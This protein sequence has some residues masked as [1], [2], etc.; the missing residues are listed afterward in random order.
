MHI[1][2]LNHY[3]GSPYYG[4]EYRPYYLA[5]EWLK[6]GHSVTI[7]AA[8]NSHIRRVNPSFQ[9]RYWEENI[10]GIHY[11]WLRTR[12]YNENGIRRMLNMLD[13]IHG[14]YSHMKHLAGLKPDVVIASSTY[15]LD[16]Y[17]AY[18]LA[19]KSRAQ[20]IYEV[21]DLWP[22]SP[23]KLGGYSKWH[24]FIVIMQIAENFA[25]RHVDK[26]VSILPCAESHMR[27][28]G[29]AEGKFFHVPNGIY[30]PEVEHAEPLDR[31]FLA[32]LPQNKKIIGYCGTLGKANA[33]HNLIEV[34]RMVQDAHPDLFFAIVGKGPEKQNL[35]SLIE[36]YRLENIQIYDAIPKVQ[37]QSFLHLCS[38]IIIIWNDC[39]I[40]K[41]GISPNKI[42]DYMYSGRPVIQAVRAGNDILKESGGGITCDMTPDSI[43]DT[44]EQMLN[45]SQSEL[46]DMGKKGNEYVLAHHTYQVLAQKFIEAIKNNFRLFYCK[47]NSSANL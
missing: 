33:L 16:N 28:H 6:L 41:Y 29:L 38:I 2:I 19:K 34:A 1:L 27:E 47:T 12:C 43:R 15:P 37:V 22:L 25:Y 44:L 21:H 4:M 7:V 23:Q 32:K 35:L 9:D 17:P 8:N 3:A 18:R 45:M 10:E 24:P 26:V 46:D 39:D 40:Y 14:L 5:K 42:F 11:I 20:L 36:K 13:Y 31:E 30:L